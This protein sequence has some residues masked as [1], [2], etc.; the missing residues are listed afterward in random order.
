VPSLKELHPCGHVNKHTKT[1]F[2]R[3]KRCFFNH[4]KL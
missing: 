4:V 3:S 1:A 2:L